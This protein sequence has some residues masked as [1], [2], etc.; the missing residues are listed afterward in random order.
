MAIF[1]RE[2]F[3]NPQASHWPGYFWFINS[4]LEADE[5]KKQKGDTLLSGSFV[6]SG[7]CYARLDKVG[8]DS[9]VSKL[10]IEAKKQSKNQKSEMMKSL[11]NLVKMF[12]NGRKEAASAGTKQPI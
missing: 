9:F 11:D 4:R 2:N 12:V 8:N 6:V 5:I 3:E 1:N 10:T 7:K